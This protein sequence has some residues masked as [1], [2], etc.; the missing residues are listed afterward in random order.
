M[1]RVVLWLVIVG[2]VGRRL[3]VA[4][5][6]LPPPVGANASLLQTALDRI[7]A[8]DNGGHLTI[9]AGTYVFS[10]TSL[11]IT[12][13]RHISVHGDGAI[14]LFY[15]GFGIAIK[16]C[17]NVTVQGLTLDSDPP[18]YAQGRVTRVD[19]H[20]AS[21]TSTFDEAFLMPD[22]SAVPFNA[23]GGSAGAKIMF[24]KADTRLPSRQVHFLKSST[25]AHGVHSWQIEVKDGLSSPLPK[26]GDLVTVFPRR[27]FTWLSHN[28]SGV[29]A[30]SIVIHAGGNMGFLETMG[31]GGHVYRNVSIVRKPG[32]RGLMA[33]NADGFHSLGVRVGPT[34]ENSEISFTGDDHLNIHASMLLVC[35]GLTPTQLAIVDP[36]DQIMVPGDT[37][38]F[39]KL[40]SSMPGHPPG[41]LNPFLAKAVVKDIRKATDPSLVQDC[42]HASTFMGQPP[43][44]AWLIVST[45]GSPVY[46]VDV[47][48]PPGPSVTSTRYSLVSLDSHLCANAKVRNNYF[49]DS[50]GSGGR[51]L[52]KSRN[53]TFEKNV[54]ERFGGIHITTEQEWLEGDLGI[55]NIVLDSNFIEDQDGFLTHVDVM[56]GVANVTC[57]NTSFV[58][59]GKTT[60]R[61]E[62]C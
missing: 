25:P 16:N 47:E 14:L 45:L 27:G 52:L 8:E 12:D 60:H 23:P 55:G 39:Y 26:T 43:Y 31:D 42:Q 51:I 11:E 17:D 37:L 5:P 44:N 9:K 15:I 46:V 38:S 61:S 13:C 53:A 21:F 10:N 32:S 7:C 4:R 35:K 34:L 29:V 56:P 24:W 20:T 40:L 18:N 58:E 62:G 57:E 6:S 49:H 59:H 22:T 36:S 48:T 50:C 41:R 2:L 30:D 28:S 3:V 1:F 54:A 33:L 19:A